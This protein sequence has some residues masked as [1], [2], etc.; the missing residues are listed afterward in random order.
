MSATPVENCNALRVGRGLLPPT[1]ARAPMSDTP[2]SSDPNTANPGGYPP[3]NPGGSYPPPNPSGY[4]PPNPGGS[5]PPPNPSGYPPPNPGAGYPPPAAPQGSGFQPPTYTPPGGFPGSAPAGQN[6]YQPNPYQPNPYGAAFQQG[7]TG[8]PYAS[9]GARAG[10]IVLNAIIYIV[11][12]I[13]AMAAFGAD[14]VFEYNTN[15]GASKNN[16]ISIAVLLIFGFINSGYLQGTT[17]A[18]LGKRVASIRVADPTTGQAIGV[19]RST[20]R[21]LINTMPTSIAG[22]LGSPALVLVAFLFMIVNFLFPLWDPQKQTIAD[23]AVKSIVVR[24]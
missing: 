6:P 5:Y 14:N 20:I 11:L 17:G 16:F 8:P 21:M 22:L 7:P 9:W 23:K 12:S 2:N 19:A 3:P 18:S 24:S 15:A 10:A 1:K 4:P 13:A